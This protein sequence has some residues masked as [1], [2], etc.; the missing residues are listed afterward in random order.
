LDDTIS[1]GVLR[2]EFKL[3]IGSYAVGKAIDRDH[4][5]YPELTALGGQQGII[6]VHECV[7]PEAILAVVH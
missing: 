4:V 5:T 7:V 1:V 3:K 6:K 2:D